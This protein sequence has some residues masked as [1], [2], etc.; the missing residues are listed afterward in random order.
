MRLLDEL[1]A[2]GRTIV[3]VT[4]DPNIARHASRVCTMKDGILLEGD[5]LSLSKG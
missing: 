1:H 5:A 2:E 4:H 3:M